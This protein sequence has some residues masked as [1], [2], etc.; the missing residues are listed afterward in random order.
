[1]Y[2]PELFPTRL[3]TTGTGICYNVGR[4]LAA[5]GPLALASF[6]KM[7]EGNSFGISGFRAA[8]ILVASSYFVGMIALI[9][10]PETKGKPL[11]E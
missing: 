6:A 3:R 10:A 8:A 7:L 4:Y 1:L 11:P 9:W 2:L 5:V